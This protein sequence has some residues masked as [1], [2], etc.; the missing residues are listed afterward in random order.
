ME[1]QKPTLE[2]F[3][4]RGDNPHI[5][6]YVFNTLKSIGVPMYKLTS[7]KEDPQYPFVAWDGE[8]VTEWS[9]VGQ[10]DALLDHKEFLA[11]FGIGKRLV[12]IPSEEYEFLLQCSSKFERMK[13]LLN[14]R[15][16]YINF[17]YLSP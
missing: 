5:R 3:A 1:Y 8:R 16:E 2:R 15:T 14:E 11:Q 12:Q 4:L 17:C 7:A 10:D 9:S 6:A 13:D